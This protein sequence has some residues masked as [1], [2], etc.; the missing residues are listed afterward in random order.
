MGLGSTDG[1]VIELHAD[2]EQRHA[3]LAGQVV[4]D[5]ESILDLW[6]LRF[7][8]RGT[9]RGRHGSCLWVWGGEGLSEYNV[10]SIGPANAAIWLVP[11]SCLS[12]APAVSSALLNKKEEAA[13]VRSK[14]LDCLP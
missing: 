1:Q 2:S 11:E 10:A 3:R 7:A 8:G 9:G 12:W 4:V 13:G 6:T 14:S 5:V